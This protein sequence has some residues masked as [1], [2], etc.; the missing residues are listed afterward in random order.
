[1]T[2]PDGARPGPAHA[3]PCRVGLARWQVDA[4]PEAFLRRVGELAGHF[5]R[6]DLFPGDFPEG[7]MWWSAEAVAP[8]ALD[9]LVRLELDGRYVPLRMRPSDD[10]DAAIVARSGRP[11]PLEVIRAGNSGRPGGAP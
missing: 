3:A 8:G 1:M 10:A 9:V 2:S 6:V 4:Y 7:E 5:V 11:L